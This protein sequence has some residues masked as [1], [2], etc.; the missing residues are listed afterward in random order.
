MDLVFIGKIERPSFDIEPFG[1]QLCDA[2]EDACTAG[3]DDQ[4]GTGGT[5]PAGD[6]HADSDLTAN[7]TDEC[8]G[9][10]SDDVRHGA[11]KGCK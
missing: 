4:S 10:L 11:S 1:T 6:C 8:H 9:V 2:F 7:P 3:G 5:Q